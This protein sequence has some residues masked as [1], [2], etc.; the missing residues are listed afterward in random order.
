MVSS[1]AR[2]G[3]QVRSCPHVPTLGRSASTLQSRSERH[4]TQ[5]APPPNDYLGGNWL[6]EETSLGV[7]WA[8]LGTMASSAGPLTKLG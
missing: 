4:P 8:Q 6:C 2:K 1:R 5:L 3:E 7:R